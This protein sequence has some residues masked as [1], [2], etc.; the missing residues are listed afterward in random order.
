[1]SSY[2]PLR[3]PNRLWDRVDFDED[4]WIWLGPVNRSGY[5][6]LRRFGYVHRLAWEL[7][8]GPIPE[9][10]TVDHLCRNRVCVRPDHLELVTRAENIRRE[11]AARKC[12]PR[13]H[14]YDDANTYLYKNKRGCRT[15]R[16]AQSRQGARGAGSDGG[17][18]LP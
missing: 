13:G 10:M 1:V 15:C 14:V 7:L 8:R 5:G 4:C 17:E 6:H 3:D 2:A 18:P 11:N 16:A 9:G 12:C